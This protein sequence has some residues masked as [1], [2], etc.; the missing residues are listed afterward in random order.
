MTQDLYFAPLTLEYAQQRAREYAAVSARPQAVVRLD[1]EFYAIPQAAEKD[2]DVTVVEVIEP[3]IHVSADDV[4]WK[5]FDE[6][7]PLTVCDE[8]VGMDD[9]EGIRAL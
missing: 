9:V 5:S 8:T 2:F 3:E 4:V 7:F 6:A 1:G